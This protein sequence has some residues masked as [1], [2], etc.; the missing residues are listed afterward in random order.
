MGALLLFVHVVGANP[1]PTV[2]VVIVP[3]VIDNTVALIRW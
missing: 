1:H 2:V 3:A